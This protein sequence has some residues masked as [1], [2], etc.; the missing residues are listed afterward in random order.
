MMT[1]MIIMLSALSV[2][3]VL[4]SLIHIVQMNGDCRSL[5]AK[6]YVFLYGMFF[7]LPVVAEEPPEFTFVTYNV[8]NLFDCRHDTLKNDLEFLPDGDRKWTWRRYKKK[9]NDIARVLHEIGE[10]NETMVDYAGFHIPDVIVLCEVENDSVIVSLTRRS[11]LRSVGYRYVITHSQDHRGVDVSIL[12]NP[13]T[14]RPDTSFSIRVDSLHGFAPT[15]DILYIKGTTRA[16]EKLHVFAL[17]APSRSS[18]EAQTEPYRLLVSNAVAY[19]VDSLL[20]DDPFTNIIVAGDFNDYSSNKSLKNL[21]KRL[22]HISKDAKGKNQDKTHVSGTYYFQGEWGSLDHILVSSSIA[23]KVTQCYIFDRDWL[24]EQDAQGSL[25]PKRTYRGPMYHGGVS[26][27]LP[28]VLKI[29][30]W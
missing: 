8:E 3:S 28:L 26:D 4:H 21:S 29:E 2:F 20:T 11:L 13:L 12:Y 24:L 9:V 30:K 19:H 7:V 15:R 18:G 10:P 22:C 6:I 25:R 5:V 27:H 23:E 17:H 14:F 16:G 1:F